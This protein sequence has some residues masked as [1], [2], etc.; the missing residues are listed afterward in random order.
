MDLLDIKNIVL[1]SERFSLSSSWLQQFSKSIPWLLLVLSFC[2]TIAVW[3]HSKQVQTAK[4]AVR[5]ERELIRTESAIVNQISNHK[6]VLYNLQAWFVANPKVTR[7]DWHRYAKV[8][9]TEK[10]YPSFHSIGF[11][12][13]IEPQNLA[14]FEA[15]VRNDGV[16]D[17]RVNLSEEAEDYFAVKYSTELER[18]SSDLGS[19][20]I[21]RVAAEKARDTGSIAMS[22]RLELGSNTGVFLFLPVYRNGELSTVAER[23][24]AIVGWVYGFWDFQRAIAPAIEEENPLFAIKIE[25]GVTGYSLYKSADFVTGNENEIKAIEIE[26]RTLQLYFSE[27]PAFNRAI[28]RL[29]P[30]VVL[31]GG[32]II[33]CLVFGMSWSIVT[34]RYRGMILADQMTEVLRDREERLRAIVTNAPVLLFALNRNGIFTLVEGNNLDVTDGQMVEV[35]GMSIFEVYR[36]Q[37]QLL[38]SY[39]RV[40]AGESIAEIAQFGEFTFDFRWSPLRG[41]NS[42]IFGAI[43]IVTDITKRQQLIVALQQSQGELKQKA[44]ELQATLNKL[45]STQTQLIQTEKLSALGQLVAGVAHEINNPINFIA[46]NVKY[47]DN[48]ARDMIELLELYQE[49]FPDPG[50]EISDKIENIELDFVIEDLQN[51]LQSMKV[52]TDRIS[53]I[54]LSLRTFSRVEQ[55]K[56]KAVDIHEGIESTLL[57][58]NHRLKEK[59][60]CLAIKLHK[61]FGLLPLVEC[62]P[63]QL[64]QVFMNILANGID[65]LEEHYRNSSIDPQIWIRTEVVEG[66]YVTIRIADN[67]PGIPDDVKNRLFDPFFTTKPVGK[68]TGLGLSISYQIVVEKHSGNLQ[69]ISSPGEG[70][71]FIIEIPI[72]QLTEEAA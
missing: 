36:Q 59:S 28:N 47:A 19:N 9:A 52:G 58:L 31:V 38:D 55:T 50:E 30:M 46:G 44:D 49:K 51:L 62:L 45:A 3:R 33:S 6:A 67:G 13:Y 64:N 5:W 27:L 24:A 40:L 7:D 10:R 29:D 68:G 14:A 41:S 4:S 15:A 2:T 70:T 25:D 57:I 72:R 61:E 43:A 34:A 37:P 1:P 48:Y 65:A 53:E 54:V 11:V 21:L 23:R 39:D 35:E 26:G 32:W 18:N 22:D 17:Y 69:C 71:E 12:A 63:G 56:F 8:L 20:P 42:E 66:D 16:S 60:D